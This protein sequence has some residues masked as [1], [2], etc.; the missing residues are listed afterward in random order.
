MDC[1]SGASLHGGQEALLAD[2]RAGPLLAAGRDDEE[3]AGS[4]HRGGRKEQVGGRTAGL[5][6]VAV[7]G[8]AHPADGD[9][10]RMGN[11]HLIDGAGEG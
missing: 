9:V 8:R 6:E 7:L 1:T 3:P 2:A 10:I 5:V 4:D 11:R